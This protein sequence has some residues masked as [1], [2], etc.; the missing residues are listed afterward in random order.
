MRILDRYILKSVLVIFSA[1]L[2]AFLFL[3]V[4][5]DLFSRLDDI[6]KQ[7]VSLYVLRQ[8]YLGYLPII[9]V[10]VAPIACLL[11]I[12]Y[13]FSRLNR[14]NEIIAMRASG[15]SIPQITQTIIIFGVI[16]SVFVFWVNDRFVPQ[17]LA[18][19][20]K[21]KAEMDKGARQTQEKEREVIKS[22]Y[23]YGAKNRLFYV[24]KFF[25]AANTME[26]ITILEHD[27]K[28][29]VIKK[30]VAGKGV[31][32][33]GVWRFYH[34]ITYDFDQNGQIK[35]EPQYLEEEIMTIPETPQEFLS[36][37]QRPDFMN[38]GQLEDYI[39]KLSKSGASG[40]IRDLTIDLYRKF[41]DPFT[42]L[43]IVFLGIPFA[44]MIHKRATGFSSLGVSIM[45]GF[46][47]YV[48]NAVF[49]ALGKAGLIMPIL[50]ASL[51]HILALGLSFYIIN[52][53]P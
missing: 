18:F 10:Q 30:I 15:L 11:A 32:N 49:I 23:M 24:N 53:L 29:N 14:D 7:G 16:L 6:L 28:Q 2:A 27:A 9:F 47:Y 8:Y 34:S 1:C 40:V 50:A 38:I 41:T 21:I 33:E 52:S 45:L 35:D 3:Y 46:L 39:W 22:L 20:E 43:I 44:L 26:G 42:S 5:I 31:Y 4:I 36:Q 12:L 25:P 13:T 19:T 51:S 37:R 17:S 48:S